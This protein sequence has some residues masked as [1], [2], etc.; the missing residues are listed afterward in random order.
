[1]WETFKLGSRI[2]L[3]AIQRNNLPHQHSHEI[4]CLKSGTRIHFHWKYISFYLP[5]GD[6]LFLFLFP[7]LDL[8]IPSAWYFLRLHKRRR[9]SR[10]VVLDPYFCNKEYSCF[11]KDSFYLPETPS[12]YLQ[13]C[14]QL[15]TWVLAVTHIIR[16]EIFYPEE[17]WNDGVE[18]SSLCIPCRG[19]PFQHFVLCDF[20]G[21]HI[22]PSSKHPSP[23]TKPEIHS[24]VSCIFIF[25]IFCSTFT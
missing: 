1:M 9:L 15:H 19:P 23:S 2:V 20:E 13:L 11:L 12:S 6:N 10:F 3:Q 22:F 8:C 14:A 16:L 25:C 4:S 24:F 17:L 7:L 18:A 5:E 21:F